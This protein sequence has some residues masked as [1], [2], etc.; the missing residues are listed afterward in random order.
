LK[1]SGAG[2]RYGKKMKRWSISWKA[3]LL[4]AIPIVVLS[5][6]SFVGLIVTSYDIDIMAQ[7]PFMITLLIA[8]FL[9]LLLLVVAILWNIATGKNPTMT[10]IWIGVGIGVLSLLISF[11][12]YTLWDNLQ[13]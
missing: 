2:Q 10:G 8:A 9:W 7:L 12:G 3:V 4:T 11:W 1:I 5:M 6:I 13:Y